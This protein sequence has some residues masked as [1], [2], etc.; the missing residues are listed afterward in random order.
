MSRGHIQRLHRLGS[1]RNAQKV[2]KQME[3]YLHSFREGYDTIYYLSKRGREMIGSKKQV[4]RSLQT[5]HALMRND[6]FFHIGCPSYWKNEMKI[7]VGEKLTIVPDAVFMKNQR[8]H[9]LE[10]DNTQTMTDNRLKIARYK[11]IFDT[12]QF[13]QHYRYFPT[14]HIVTVSRSRVKRFTEMCEGLS[15]QVYLIDEIM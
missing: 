7:T 13:Q 5:R 9:F 14:L 8:Y 10:V 2:L 4:K 11:A 3:E 12:G 15:A 6:F 1:V